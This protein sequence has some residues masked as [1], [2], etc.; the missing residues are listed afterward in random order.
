MV[1]LPLP[2]PQGVRWG[3]GPELL[4]GNNQFRAGDRY[5]PQRR[6]GYGSTPTQRQTRGYREFHYRVPTYP[7]YAYPR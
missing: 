3:R 2:Y 6:G 4:A 7:D 1:Y 5:E